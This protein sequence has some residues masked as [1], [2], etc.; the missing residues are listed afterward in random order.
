VNPK[1]RADGPLSLTER[2]ENT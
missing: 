2:R 1:A